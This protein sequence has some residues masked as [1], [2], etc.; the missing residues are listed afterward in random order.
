[1]KRSPLRR[2]TPLPR[3]RDPLAR[4]TLNPVSER[5]RQVNRKRAKV[6]RE[7]W[8]PPST[9]VCSLRGVAGEGGI[10]PCFGAVHAHEILS[11][12]RAGRT[13]ANLLDVANM[14]PLCDF[15]NGWVTA[16][17]NAARV[18]WLTIHAWEVGPT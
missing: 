5:R 3:S 12:A 11:R 13:D 18:P 9:W 1:M 7:A 14:T 4:T 10:P 15:H 16:P 8:G 17:A 6:L 2:L